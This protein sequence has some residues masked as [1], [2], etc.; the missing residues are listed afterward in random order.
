MGPKKKLLGLVIFL[1]HRH[2][3]MQH[4]SLESLI[5]LSFFERD[6]AAPPYCGSPNQ[7]SRFL[8]QSYMRINLVGHTFYLSLERNFLS[9]KKNVVRLFNELIEQLLL[10]DFLGSVICNQVF[11]DSPQQGL[12]KPWILN[13][14][15][16]SVQNTP[17]R[18]V[19][20]Q[21]WFNDTR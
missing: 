21:S 6:K 15:K 4:K 20:F 14:Q 19:S 10:V 13:P 8:S 1:G 9:A 3:S 5:I 17:K 12:L 16:F 11:V 18:D 7:Q 2:S